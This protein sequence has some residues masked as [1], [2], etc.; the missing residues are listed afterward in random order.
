MKYKQYIFGFVFLLSFSS[1]AQKTDKKL[2]KQL[3]TIIRSFNGEA[4][5]YVKDLKRNKVVAINADSIFPTASII[6]IPILIGVM[7]KINRGELNY[8]QNLEY[9]DS[10][11]YAGVDIL[12]SFRDSQKIELGKV[13]MLMLTMSDNTASL[14]LQYHAG[15]GTRI[16]QLLDSLG[17]SNTRVNSRTPGRELNRAQYGWGQTTPLEM[18]SLMEKIV[19]GEIISKEKSAWMLRLLGRNYWDENA[20]SQ[21]PPDVFVASKNGAVNQVRNEVVYVSGKGARYVF[22]ICTKNNKDV[23]W[24]TENEAWEMTRKI[25]KLLYEKYSD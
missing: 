8:H 17:Y 15:T 9:R 4:G 16:N 25:S 19:K 18:A 21:I 12:G 2:K 7:D 23:S 13:I 5:I 10:L 24:K 1:F 14:W 3:E 22:C 20:L 6:K 11:L